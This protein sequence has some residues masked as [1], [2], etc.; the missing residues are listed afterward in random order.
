MR[1]IIQCTQLSQFYGTDK[2][3]CT[4]IVPLLL[5]QAT[6]STP[7]SETTIFNERNVKW[8]ENQSSVLDGLVVQSLAHLTHTK[9]IKWTEAFSNDLYRWLTHGWRPRGERWNSSVTA[10]IRRPAPT[11]YPA[12]SL[13]RW[14]T[15]SGSLLTCLPIDRHDTPF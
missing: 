5:Y 13:W 11:L 7:A 6:F 4:Q 1:L 3:L 14:D 15:G 12:S 8:V 10:A 2:L 9:R